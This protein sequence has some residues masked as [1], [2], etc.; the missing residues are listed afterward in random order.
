MLT[1]IDLGRDG[2]SGRLTRVVGASMKIVALWKAKAPLRAINV[3]F[4][5]KILH[6]ELKEY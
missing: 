2:E 6:P 4:G 3:I 1:R 5:M